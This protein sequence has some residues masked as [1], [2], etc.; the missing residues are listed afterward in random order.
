MTHAVAHPK[1]AKKRRRV[2]A[3]KWARTT[4]LIRERHLEKFKVL[5]WWE[6]TTIK[7][8]FDQMIE[9]YLSSKD[10]IDRLIEE[11]KRSVPSKDASS[12]AKM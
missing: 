6:K 8:L 5:A 1:T 10:Q 11:R 9:E 12:T 3:D 7:D 2:A 4:V